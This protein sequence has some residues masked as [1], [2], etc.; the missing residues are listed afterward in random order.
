MKPLFQKAVNEHGEMV[1]IRTPQMQQVLTW[2]HTSMLPIAITGRTGGNLETAFEKEIS[3]YLMK[4]YLGKSNRS[5]INDLL[6]E[7][8]VDIDKYPQTAFD[9]AAQLIFKSKILKQ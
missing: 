3:N 1:L 9:K 8:G 5:W 6:I 2:S 7:T 4:L